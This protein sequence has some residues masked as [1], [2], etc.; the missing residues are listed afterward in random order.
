MEIIGK[1]KVKFGARYYIEFVNAIEKI[2]S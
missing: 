1:L 2:T